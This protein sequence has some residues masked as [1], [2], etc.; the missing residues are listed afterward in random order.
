M[1]CRLSRLVGSFALAWLCATAVAQ[2]RE[3]EQYFFQPFLGD[4]HSELDAAHSENK[5]GILVIYEMEECPFCD[6]FHKT[7]LREAAVQDFF[8]RYFLVFRVDIKGGNRVTGFDGKELSEKAFAAGHGVRATP[9]TVFYDLAGKEMTRYTGPARD[10]R[11]FLLLG[12]YVLDEAYRNQ[13]FSQY[14][15]STGR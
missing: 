5:R 8:R 15:R 1:V 13:P 3:P 2:T 12:Q 10:A 4:F 7:V 6:R 11:E 9:T 14:K